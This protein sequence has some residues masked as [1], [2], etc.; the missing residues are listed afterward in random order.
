MYNYAYGG[1]DLYY[2][3]S[4][5]VVQG[6][7]KRNVLPSKSKLWIFH[8]YGHNLLI[9]SFQPTI[10]GAWSSTMSSN[11]GHILIKLPIVLDP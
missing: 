10:V 5:E 6:E 2:S 7:A 9:F 11:C 4:V 1:C 3:C 8:Y